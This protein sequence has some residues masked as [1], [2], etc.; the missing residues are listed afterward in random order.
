V[1]KWVEMME[2]GSDEPTAVAVVVEREAWS[3]V[4]VSVFADNVSA[5]LL[6]NWDSRSTSEVKKRCNSTP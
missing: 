5:T 6:Q 3:A 1:R 4:M 2:K